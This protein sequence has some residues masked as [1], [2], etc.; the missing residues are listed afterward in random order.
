MNTRTSVI[1]LVLVL[2]VVGLAI[3]GVIVLGNESKVEDDIKAEAGA[4]TAVS[5]T[6]ESEPVPIGVIPEVSDTTSAPV[7][8][9]S[10][11]VG[12]EKAEEYARRTGLMGDPSR[13]MARQTTLADY[14]RETDGEEL[15]P[16]AAKVGLSP[17][18]PVW[19]VIFFGDI[20]YAGHG[21]PKL[22]GTYPELRYDNIIIVINALSGKYIAMAAYDNGVPDAVQSFVNRQ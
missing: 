15:G 20:R 21:F 14:M 5:N 10:R 7:E 8:L 19:M 9:M 13:V 2:T 1:L 17:D 11:E 22:D 3:S 18:M 12:I 16:D 6:V 4:T